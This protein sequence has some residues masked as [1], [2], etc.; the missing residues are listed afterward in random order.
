MYIKL[1]RQ[2]YCRLFLFT[3]SR[4]CHP[5]QPV[6]A[7][8]PRSCKRPIMSWSKVC[9]NL[10]SSKKMLLSIYYVRQ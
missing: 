6:A 8:E 10:D 5:L 3:E 1:R 9:N 4:V 2:F 7:T